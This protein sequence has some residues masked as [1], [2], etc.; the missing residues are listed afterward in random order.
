MMR[1]CIS[2]LGACLLPAL[3]GVGCSNSPTPSQSGNSKIVYSNLAD[4]DTEKEVADLLQSHSVTT[5]QTDPLL[6]WAEDFNSRITSG[7]LP[8]VLLP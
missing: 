4:A 2:I 8:Q 5:E 7:T 6:S 3:L 1:K